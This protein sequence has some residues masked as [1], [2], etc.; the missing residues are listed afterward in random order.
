MQSSK[1]LIAATEAI[2]LRARPFGES[3][4]I[5]SFFTRNHGKLT[6]IAKG[7]K[8]SRRRFVNSLEPFSLVTLRFEERP[9][10]SLVF[11]HG[12][13]LQ[14]VCKRLRTSLE[15]IALAS[16]FVE[17]V[18]ELT[19]EREDSQ[20]VFEHLKSALLLL[21]SGLSGAP[22]VSYFEL[23]LLKLAG[24]QPSLEACTYCGET[25]ALSSGA[26]SF[27]PRDGGVLC[28]RCAVRRREAWP[29][30][31]AALRALASLRLD[32]EAPQAQWDKEVAAE[33]RQIL[34]RFIEY[35]L[36]KALKSTTFLDSIAS[37]ERGV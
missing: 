11:I 18:D 16:Y 33:S 22:F 37:K 4:K 20:A 2:V 32:A 17:L 10:W 28:A 31:T 8:R 15:G 3:D 23:R 35:Q 14:T 19:R 29:V 12:C 25:G 6:G 26:W 27:S 1:K 24:Y 5:V 13:E 21:D 30:S 36:S 7:A 9:Q 34:R